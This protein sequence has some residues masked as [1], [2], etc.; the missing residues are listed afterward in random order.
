MY[1]F[2]LLWCK[3]FQQSPNQ[4]QRN[5]GQYHFQETSEEVDMG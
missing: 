4:H 3:N 2:H 1:W 5:T